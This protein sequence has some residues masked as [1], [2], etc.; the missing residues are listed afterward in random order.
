MQEKL[1]KLNTDLK[2]KYGLAGHDIAM[3]D[4]HPTYQVFASLIG[5]ENALIVG[6]ELGGTNIYLPRLNIEQM[7]FIR[8]RNRSIV[9]EFNGQNH[10]I[11]ARKYGITDITVREILKKEKAKQTKGSN[12]KRENN[13]SKEV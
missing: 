4:L 12:E 6:R 9:E 5:V 10:A 11:L 2:E 13:L 7:Q 3:K 8:E 1:P